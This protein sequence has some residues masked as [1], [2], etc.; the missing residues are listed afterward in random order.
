M[1][2]VTV[3]K[4]WDKGA[5]YV[6]QG[7][8]LGN[9]F[10]FEDMTDEER[11]EV[12][13][14][15][16]DYFYDQLDNNSKFKST[17][18]NLIRRAKTEKIILGCYCTPKL[19]HAITIK[20]YIDKHTLLTPLNVYMGT[21]ENSVLSNLAH[22]P[23]KDKVSGKKFFSVEHAY[24]SLKSGSFDE[25][26][27]SKYKPNKPNKIPGTLGT[28]TNANWNLNLMSNLVLQSFQQ[29][30]LIAQELLDT[31]N[32]PITHTQDKGIWKK[33]FPRILM[34]VREQLK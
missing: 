10:A 31:G 8:I 26:T 2:N 12:C 4:K 20:K 27:Y 13:D 28:L 18:D 7:S 17:L 32:R 11:K 3:G 22:R 15:Y 30:P 29:N 14:Q 23:F 16:E 6:G 25:V 21:N 5:V 9:P 33:E 34:E 24:Q 1:S 19:C